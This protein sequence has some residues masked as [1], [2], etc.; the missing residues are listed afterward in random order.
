MNNKC[1]KFS[2]YFIITI[3]SNNE[4]SVIP[5]EFDKH[6]KYFILDNFF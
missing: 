4:D 1:L 6:F 2:F 3:R 5:I